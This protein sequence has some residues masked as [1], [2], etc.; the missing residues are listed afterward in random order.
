MTNLK[1]SICTQE[2]GRYS[3]LDAYVDYCEGHVAAAKAEGSDVILFPEMGNVGLLWSDP[4]AAKLPPREVGK[5]YDAVL[6]PFFAPFQQRMSDLAVR[7]GIV[8]IAPSFW[9]KTGGVGNNTALIVFPDGRIQRQDKIHL[10]RPEQAIDT[11]AGSSLST[12]EINGVKAGLLICYDSQWPELARPLVEAGIK[13]LFVPSLTGHRGYWR[14]RYAT[15]ARAQEGQMYVCVAGLFG[16]LGIPEDM[17]LTAHGRAYVTCPADNRFG[18]EDGLY[19]EGPMDED[20]LLTV[21]LDIDL[22]DLSREKGEIRN[23]KDRRDDLYPN[24]KVS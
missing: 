9:H 1:V 17:P 22:V 3:T 2:I 7:H 12:F 15:Q 16:D 11:K 20:G 23:L 19:A 18:V 5:A 14:V 6:T 8:V 4:N 13:V 10:T 21:E 24:L